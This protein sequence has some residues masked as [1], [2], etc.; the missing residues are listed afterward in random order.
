MAAQATG[1]PYAN[2]EG[3]RTLQYGLKF[4]QLSGAGD[5]EFSITFT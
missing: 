4:P 2:R 1:N 3:Q 5:D